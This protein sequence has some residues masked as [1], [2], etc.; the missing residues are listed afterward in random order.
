MALPF[1]VTMIPNYV[2]VSQLGLLG[3]IGGGVVPQLA[4]AFAVLLM[5]QHKRA[6]PAS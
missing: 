2:L 3:T 1:Q 4:G 5:V 6:F